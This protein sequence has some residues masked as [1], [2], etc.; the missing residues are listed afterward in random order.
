VS[1]PVTDAT[2][3]D[4]LEAVVMADERCR[5]VLH[6][7]KAI[8]EHG[9]GHQVDFTAGP[10]EGAILAEAYINPWPH[11]HE[12]LVRLYETLSG[13][14]SLN[15]AYENFSLTMS[16]DGRGHVTVDVLAIADHV[17][18]IQLRF[19]LYLDQTQLPGIIKAVKELFLEA[20]RA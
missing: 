1:K 19:Q 4:E 9:L 12:Q 11:F 13:E 10:F 17:R 18:P 5:V 3:A 14:A 15:P 20:P 16:G 2:G 8:S 7:P 6:P